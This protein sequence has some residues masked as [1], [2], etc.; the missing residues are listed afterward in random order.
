MKSTSKENISFS[1][2]TTDIIN[3]LNATLSKQSIAIL[4]ELYYSTKM[5]QKA[6]AANIHTSPSSLSN[7]LSRLETIDPQL[8]KSERIGRSKY[9]SLTEIAESYIEQGI[10]HKIATIHT[11][12]SASQEKSLVNDTLYILHQFQKTAG[13]EWY[14]ILDDMLSNKDNISANTSEGNE[15]NHLYR[16]FVNNMKQLQ[17]LENIPAIHEVQSILGDK[18]LIKR[19]EK[20]ISNELKHYYALAPLF[21]LEK[22]NPE[23]AFLYTDNLFLQIEPNL[24]KSLDPSLFEENKNIPISEEQYNKIF[25]EFVNLKNDFINYQGNKIKAVQ[26]WKNIYNVNSTL[27]YY[28]AEK[29]YSS[30]Y[31]TSR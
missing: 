25:D 20:L 4:K 14:L 9:Y 11:F 28:I 15:L 23:K 2:I 7:T 8:L 26:N 1:T 3:S 27:L 12:A 30:C 10:P 17:K 21:K 19:L 13:H 31:L 6:L 16:N 24:F 18:T 5:Q 29:C 22:Q